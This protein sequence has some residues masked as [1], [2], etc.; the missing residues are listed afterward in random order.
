[1][2]SDSAGALGE[3]KSN[4]AGTR[5]GTKSNESGAGHSARD[6]ARESTLVDPDAPT[7]APPP[8]V[9]QDD[10]QQPDVA[11]CYDLGPIPG[12]DPLA[13]AGDCRF[14]AAAAQRAIDFFHE[15]LT[16]TAGEWMGQPFL[17]QPWQRAIIGNLF[18]W[19]RSDGRRRYREAFIFVPRKC[20]KSELAGGLGNLLTFADGEPAAQVYCAAADREQARLVFNAAK[21]MVMAEPELSSRGRIYTNAIHVESTGSVLKVISAEAYSKHGLNAS[22]IIIDEL[23]AQPNRDLVDVLTTSI[24]ARRQP[25]IVYITTSDYDRESICNEKY[26]Y[27]CKV[28]DGIIADAAFLPVIYE[29]R[30]DEDWTDPEVWKRANPNLGVSIRH[31][32]L[33]RECQRAIETPTYENSFKRLHLN[34]K[35]Q[36]DV[37]WLRLEAWDACG[38]EPIDEAA[39]AR[40]PCSAG[41][42][43]STTTDLSALALLFPE[44]AEGP[45]CSPKRYTLLCR[46]WLPAENARQRERRDRVPYETWARQGLIEL[47]PGSV[48][49]YDRIRARIGEL[50]Q[51]FQIKE[52]AVDPW[53]ATQ[54]ALQ[55]QADCFKVLTFGQNFKDMTAPCKEFEKIIVSGKLRHGGNPVLRWMASNVAVETD[56]AGNLKPSKKKST[57]R[58]DGIVATVMALG[59]AMLDPPFPSPYLDRGPV[60]V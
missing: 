45:T 35:T 11:H 18:G 50:G 10:I 3:A 38:Q 22:G 9:S 39:L 15:C 40:K 4:R 6:S 17:L 30:P 41:L 57:E 16:F 20:G 2:K 55:L 36:Q 49:D 1:V 37:R 53:N 12:Y 31:E 21:T 27:A 14:D 5:R 52:I 44:G 54:L 51:Q 46:F 33:D 7:D 28:R 42:D 32:Y 60:F 24:G 29:A 26:D 47:T 58:I 19:K 48:I 13:S 59:R 43:L 25:L 8:E 34:M 23:H 56:A